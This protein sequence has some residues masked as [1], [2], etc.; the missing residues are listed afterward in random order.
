MLEKQQRLDVLIPERLPLVNADNR[1]LKQVLLNL[2]SNAHKFTPEGGRICLVAKQDPNAVTVAVSDTGVGMTDD[3][4]RSA[5]KPFVQVKSQYTRD[6]E[7]TGLGLPIAKA[8]IEM[9]GGR[10]LVSST[11]GAGTTVAF[12]LTA[13]PAYRPARPD[14]APDYLAGGVR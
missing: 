1:R 8:L 7:G 11:P 2:L 6:Q 10:F 13:V 3:Q 5:L 12:T 4:I 14:F 9:H